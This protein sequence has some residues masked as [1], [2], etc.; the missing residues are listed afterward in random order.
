MTDNYE[1]KENI[2]SKFEDFLQKH[3]INK[4]D[5][6]LDIVDNENE[7]GINIIG[8]T[9]ECMFVVY[10]LQNN[11]LKIDFVKHCGISISLILTFIKEIKD[12]YGTDYSLSDA[13]TFYFVNETTSEKLD[14]SL[15]ELYILC[16]GKTFYSK[17]LSDDLPSKEPTINA[18]ILNIIPFNYDEQQV[19]KH[20]LNRE[21]IINIGS[22]FI[23]IKDDFKKLT[24]HTKG[25]KKIIKNEDW[26]IIKYYRDI[27]TK[28]YA[29][30]ENP[31][32]IQTKTISSPQSPP[33]SKR[34]R[35]RYSYSLRSSKKRKFQSSS[36]IMRSAKRK[37]LIALQ[38]KSKTN[39]TKR[40]QK[41]IKQNKTKNKRS[42]K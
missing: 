28:T 37:A 14:I 23:Y 15:R 19:I 33:P 20:I 26:N 34:K 22:F 11:K 5:L 41:Q 32:N 21:G 16:Y 17:I 7:I 42:I 2:K 1:I 31:N 27:I 10:D 18:S 12:F 4:Y 40:N 25:D 3:N 29:Y 6:T 24:I 38:T 39:K 8:S 36:L 13:S 35:K 9:D 30:L